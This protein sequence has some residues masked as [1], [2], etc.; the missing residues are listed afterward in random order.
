MKKL[1]GLL[2]VLSIC[3]SCSD[4]GVETINKPLSPEVS[5]LLADVESLEA[6]MADDL[7]L[8]SSTKEE[9]SN[10][11]YYLKL[12]RVLGLKLN[13]SPRDRMAATELFKILKKI[14]AFPFSSRDAGLF[15]GVIY[16]LRIT[17]DKYATIQDL[18]LEGLEWGLF[19]FK[20]AATLEP[21]KTINYFAESALWKFGRGGGKNFA[22]VESRNKIADA[23]LFTPVLDLTS[24][25]KQILIIT[26]T[27]RNPEWENF[28]VMISTDYL[29]ADPLE[30]T[31]EEVVIKPTRNVQSNQ[32]VN[33]VTNPIDVS[34]YAG[35]KI[36]VAFQFK[37]T[38]KSNSVWEI[39]G[40]ELK[41]TGDAVKTEELEI[42]YEA[43][44]TDTP[45]ED[46]TL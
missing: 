28:K 31:W 43:P 25:K 2:L 32:W 34:K 45:E 46:G 15:E 22:K 21:F 36:V 39:L 12:S 41:G 16:R 24:S 33:L 9:I 40:V 1:I 27:V 42:T 6:S 19:N 38:E 8:R 5:L 17:L 20:F 4:G 44:V 30:S 11:K 10:I 3:T 18:D 13:Q 26:H 14:E 23:W 7:I 37:A 29:G 35:K